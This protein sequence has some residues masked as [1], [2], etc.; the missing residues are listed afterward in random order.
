MLCIYSLPMHS[1]TGLFWTLLRSHSHLHSL[2]IFFPTATKHSIVLSCPVFSRV[3][4]DNRTYLGECILR[5][6]TPHTLPLLGKLGETI[7][8]Q[9]R[10]LVTLSSTCSRLL[11]W[12]NLKCTLKLEAL[13]KVYLQIPKMQRVSEHKY[14]TSISR[15]PKNSQNAQ[16]FITL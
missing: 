12:P 7:L 13:E 4:V 14:A 9:C 11:R 8:G 15:Q 10:C 3:Y 16:D 2:W 6:R 1:K 5:R